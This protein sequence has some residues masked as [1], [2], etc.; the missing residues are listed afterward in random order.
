MARVSSGLCVRERRRARPGYLYDS[1]GNDTLF[2]RGD[3]GYLTDS[4][5]SYYL[6]FKYFDE[7]FAH[8]EDDDKSTRDIVNVDK[9][10][11]YLLELEGH[12]EPSEVAGGLAALTR[13]RKSL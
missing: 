5:G 8:S 9:S 11:L 10:L 12:G 13:P 1:S 2:G 4:R 6:Y 3:Y 7:I